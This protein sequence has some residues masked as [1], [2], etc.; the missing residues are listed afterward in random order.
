VIL[1]ARTGVVRLMRRYGNTF[2]RHEA[3]SNVFS[4]K[5]RPSAVNVKH[6]LHEKQ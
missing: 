1:F 5:L 6:Q 3:H 2:D 4:R